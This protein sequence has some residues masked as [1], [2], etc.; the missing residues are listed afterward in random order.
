MA[1][2]HLEGSGRVKWGLGSNREHSD[3]NTGA[4]FF[5]VVQI[6]HS[7]VVISDGDDDGRRRCRRSVPFVVV[8]CNCVLSFCQYA[9]YEGWKIN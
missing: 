1:T 5:L 8:L 9:G 3:D 6:S 2:L 4:F 7:Q